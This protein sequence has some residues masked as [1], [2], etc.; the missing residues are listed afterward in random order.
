LTQCNPH[1]YGAAAVGVVVC[2]GVVLLWHLALVLFSLYISDSSAFFAFAPLFYV[3]FIGLPSLIYVIIGAHTSLIVW[4]RSAS[5]K[6]L[7]EVTDPT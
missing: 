3:L 6:R 4:R 7:S 5:T 2:L 1:P